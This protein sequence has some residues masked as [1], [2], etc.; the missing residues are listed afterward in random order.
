M[1]P[2]SVHLPRLLAFLL[3]LATLT[4]C[5]GPRKPAH[6]RPGTIPAAQP[7]P[8]AETPPGAGPIWPARAPAVYAESAILIDAR[9]GRVLY[10]KNADLRRPPASTQKLLTAI[11]ILEE[12][13]LD[14]PFN[15]AVEDTRVEPVKLGLRPGQVHT[16]RQLLTAM[17]I[18]SENDAAMA[19]ARNHSGSAPAFAMAMNQR[20][21]QLGASNSWFANPTGLP[22][23]QFSTA[24]DIARIAHRAWRF[25]LLRQIVDTR[26]HTFV[27][28]NGRTRR[29][30]NTNKLLARSPIFNGMKTGYT[31]AAGRCLVASASAGGR[32]LIFVQLGSRTR[33]IF[34]DAE[35][36]LRWGLGGF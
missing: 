19:L 3:V 20:A 21:R 22:A 36:M 27:F 6:G 10:Q 30:E 1:L 28:N 2:R 16:P 26:Y 31:I 7:V 33:Y 8:V 25:A 32:E 15:I 18:K 29:L 24:R 11:L 17:L 34:D 5:A 23:N 13:N 4:A 14:R 35:R 12:G 9:S